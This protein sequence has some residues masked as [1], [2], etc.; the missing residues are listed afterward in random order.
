MMWSAVFGG[1][2][3]TRRVAVF[4]LSGWSPRI[5][6]SRHSKPTRSRVCFVKPAKVSMGSRCL[7]QRWRR[8]RDSPGAGEQVIVR[9]PN[10]GALHQA[11]RALPDL[12]EIARIRGVRLRWDVDPR[13]LM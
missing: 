12:Q 5:A 3:A 13:H 2:W 6:G 9:A 8:C 10:A 11:L 7:G 4:V 1:G